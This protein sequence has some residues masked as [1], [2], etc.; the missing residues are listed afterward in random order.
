MEMKEPKETSGAIAEKEPIQTPPQKI[1]HY[2]KN[3]LVSLEKTT[4]YS[5][6][7][8]KKD[9]KGK[10]DYLLE[11]LEPSTRITNGQSKEDMEFTK[12]VFSKIERQGEWTR[13]NIE[14][15]LNDILKMVEAYETKNN[16]IVGIGVSS[17]KPISEKDQNLL[18]DKYGDL[19]KQNSIT[20]I[21]PKK[22]K[23]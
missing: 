3:I 10:K 15:C 17:K 20:A 16:S 18:D 7:E 9:I 19:L 23:I 6:D 13:E 1:R 12:I 2:L 8:F 14:N 5:E 22:T 11:F 21:Y 4:P